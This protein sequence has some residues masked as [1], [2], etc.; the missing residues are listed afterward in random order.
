M[1]KQKVRSHIETNISIQV[2]K[3]KRDKAQA[4]FEKLRE[5]FVTK[6]AEYS[7]YS[8]DTQN[9]LVRLQGEYRLLSSLIGS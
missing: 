2:L 4:D 9:E 3:E 6:E 1:P 8:K 5:E 7:K